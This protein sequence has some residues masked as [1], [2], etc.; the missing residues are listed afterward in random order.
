MLPALPF[1]KSVIVF[2]QMCQDLGNNFYFDKPVIMSL[3]T[4]AIFVPTGV[5]N[6]VYPYTGKVFLNDVSYGA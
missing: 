1:L 4:T 2:V 3:V 6:F 5:H